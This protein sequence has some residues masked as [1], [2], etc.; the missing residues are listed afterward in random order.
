MRWFIA[1]LFT[2]ENVERQHV[3]FV[4][5]AGVTLEQFHEFICFNMIDYN[6]NIIKYPL[7]KHATAQ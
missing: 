1:K 6:E 2:V 4:E 5:F 7:T 3:L